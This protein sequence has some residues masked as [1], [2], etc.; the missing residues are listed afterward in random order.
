MKRALAA[1]AFALSFT[2]TFALAE[3]FAPSS[4]EHL[5]GGADE[6]AGWLA[7]A[8]E[9][10]I[11]TREIGERILKRDAE[12]YAG[13]YLLGVA[14][15]YGE[16]DLAR[17]A[18]HLEKAVARFEAKFGDTPGEDKPWRWHEAALRELGFTYGEMDKP[19]DELRAFEKRDH[20]YL[21]KRN[22]QRVWPLMKLRRY[23]EAREAARL[24]V[25]TGDFNQKIIAR[26]DLCAAECEAGSREKAFT[27]CVDALDT[28]RTLPVG[29]MVEYSNA[30]E[31]ALS[32]LKYAEAERFLGESTKRAVP[33]SW[34]NPYQHLA[35][36]YLTEGRIPEAI[37][38][39]KSGQELRLRRPAWLDQHG[40]ARLDGTL[41]D[42]LLIV[43][44]TDRAVQIA[45][46]AVD[47][48]DRQ[49]TSSGTEKQATAA[50][51]LRLAVALRE[52]ARR[53]WEA[54]VT[55]PFMEAGWYRD[56]AA[57]RAL[58]AWRERKRA[59]VL[60]S[61]ED[62]L[63]RSIRPYYVGGI[64]LPTFD[65]VELVGAVGSGVALKAIA[66]ARQEETMAGAG[67]FFDALTAEAEF[68]RG[69]WERAQAAAEQAFAKLPRAE[70]LLRGRAA[71]IAG[72]SALKLGQRQRAEERFAFAL[73]AD[74]GVLRRLGLELPVAIETDGSE[75]A[76]KAAS[77]VRRSPRFAS[78]PASGFH[79][80]VR[81]GAQPEACLLG[82]TR[83]RIACAQV[84]L[85]ASTSPGE[86]ARML[87]A[88]LHRAAFAIKVDLSQS[89]LTTLDG[90]PTAQRADH[91]V[92]QLLDTLGDDR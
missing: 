7:A 34:G 88:E 8:D 74:P 47:R 12:S 55:A 3:D 10:W 80:A 51:A 25:A 4:T 63:V 81:G 50:S 48:P 36:L 2:G 76:E 64:D 72:A 66:R 69:D 87:A 32:V 70:A 41:A 84:A 1:I 26:S 91:Q 65:Y 40:Q 35:T 82:P 54:S 45:Q 16:G 18:W 43:G 89:D 29:G 37:E 59:A 56:R 92:K 68:Q 53:D 15:H 30:S 38:S 90:S 20:A 11:K 33:D 71:A 83:D 39:L 9:K 61:D 79:L 75:L 27:A 6:V 44:Q 28:F 67:P 31:A 85:K 49:G 21:P 22:A 17:S 5:G 62:F 78:D 52:Q 60:L 14:M 13:H 42:L 46:R 58:A 73:A 57:W 19:A 23:D 86:S 24:A 77:I